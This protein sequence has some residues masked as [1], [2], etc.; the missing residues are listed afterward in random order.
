VDLFSRHNSGTYNN[1]WMVLDTALFVPNTALPKSDLL[2]IAEQIPGL[3]ES[4]DVTD[5]LLKQGYWS[6][7][8]FSFN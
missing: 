3:V 1:Q 6:V 2:W 5:V 4:A 8:T 7:L